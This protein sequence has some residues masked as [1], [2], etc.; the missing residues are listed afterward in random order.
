MDE[1]LEGEMPV[2]NPRTIYEGRKAKAFMGRG[3]C[4]V[5]N[6]TMAGIEHR[7]VPS[8]AQIQVVES[9]MLYVSNSDSTISGRATAAYWCLIYHRREY[10][11]NKIKQITVR[12]LALY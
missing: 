12:K 11:A 9:V 5:D 1:T 4:R 2:R 8:T 7:T 6:S 10:E 3:K